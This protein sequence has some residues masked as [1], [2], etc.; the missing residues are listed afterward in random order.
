MLHHIGSLVPK[1][2][3]AR[4]R[5]KRA[6]GRSSAQL[7]PSEKGWILWCIQGRALGLL[8]RSGGGV[9]SDSDQC[10]LRLASGRC[11]E[12]FECRAAAQGQ[13]EREREKC[14]TCAVVVCFCVEEVP[15]HGFWKDGVV[16]EKLGGISK[17]KRR[18][19]LA[20]IWRPY[21]WPLLAEPSSTAPTLR[22]HLTTRR[23]HFGWGTTGSFEPKCNDWGLFVARAL[24][25]C[26]DGQSR[27]QRRSAI[28]WRC[29]VRRSSPTQLFV[30]LDR[31]R[32]CCIIHLG[33]GPLG[34]FGHFRA[35]A[36]SYSP[37]AKLVRVHRC[38][39]AD[40]F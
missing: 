28:Q 19:N 31:Q 35:C 29:C 36:S 18:K 21:P 17:V 12:C 3:G 7:C 11:H 32:T 20:S 33:F 10:R 34:E 23:V 40:V 9:R 8:L 16:M 38:L 39:Q 27:E 37:I 6:H 30:N 5:P 13:A 22:L 26:A 24:S 1:S 14:R 2:S 4:L 15:K 25:L